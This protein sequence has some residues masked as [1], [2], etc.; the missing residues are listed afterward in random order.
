METVMWGEN[1]P[2]SLVDTNVRRSAQIAIGDCKDPEYLAAKD[3]SKGNIPNYRCYSNN[4]VVCNDINEILDNEDFWKG[5]EGNGEPYGLINLK[6]SRSCGRLGETQYPDPGVD[7]YNPCLT[8]DTMILTSEGLRPITK[9]LGKKFT[10]VVDGKL[11]DSTDTGF[12]KTGQREVYKITLENGCQIK[13]TANHKFLVENGDWIPVSDLTITHNI[14]LGKNTNFRWEGEGTFDEG[15]LVGHTTVNHCNTKLLLLSVPDDI[16]VDNY[17]PAKIIAAFV[18]GKFT[19]DP[20]VDSREGRTRYVI[21]VSNFR[22]IIDRFQLPEEGSYEFS[23]GYLKGLFDAE[24]RICGNSVSLYEL[25]GL[26]LRGIQRLLLAMGINSVIIDMDLVITGDSLA[27]FA[28]IIGFSDIDRTA[29][30]E[31]IISLHTSPTAFVS[32]IRSIRRCPSQDVYDCTIN[33]VHRFSA[34]GLISHNCAEQGLNS[35]E[36]CC[37]SELYL[38]NIKTKE[39]LFTCAKY[40]Y[41]I[42]KHSLTLPCKDSKETEQV[43]HQNMRI[44]IGVTGYLQATEVQKGWL[45]DCYK[46]LR[47]LDRQ[48]SIQHGFPFSIKLTTCK[49]SGCSRKDTLVLTNKGLLRLDEIGDVNG[50]QWQA[51]EKLQVFTDDTKTEN[52]TK[53]YVNG[54]VPTRKIITMDGAE[55]ESSLNH[56]YRLVTTD[57]KYVWKTTADLEIG[58]SLAVCLGD[59]PENIETKLDTFDLQGKM[60][61]PTLLTKDIAWFLGLFY[62]NGSVHEKGITLSFED[63]A[64]ELVV[65]LKNFFTDYFGLCLFQAESGEY[66]DNYNVDSVQFLTWLDHHSC[67]KANESQLTLPKIIR[68]ASKENATAF[69]DG[70]CRKRMD[71]KIHDD[72]GISIVSEKFARELLYVCRSVGYNARL[73]SPTSGTMNRW[74]IYCQQNLDI[75]SY[76]GLPDKGCHDRNFWLDPIVSLEASQCETYDIE[77]ENAHHYRVAGGTISHNTLSLLGGCTSGVHPGFSQYY[78]RPYPYR[79]RVSSASNCQKAWI[80]SRVCE[81]F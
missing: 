72:W 10:A 44:G 79:F 41:R 11:F 63:D 53:F 35:F 74:Y 46:Y 73:T 70:L 39:E 78:R 26:R 81:E 27:K 28:E 17:Q 16:G 4:S 54:L 31:S 37:L 23:L 47:E 61:Q 18:K 6:L 24:G 5:Y 62:A 33:E 29:Q 13:A 77:V 80:S 56:Q 20:C 67:L 21:D 9:L 71:A 15:Y 75:R 12:W 59:H 50:E 57:S 64:S 36:T 49:P 58:D 45:S 3:W 43:V 60:K 40:M 25:Y 14:V 68:M 65:W 69:I 38:P 76:K 48:Y 32:K 1:S 66:C 7:G 22:H 34:N 51:V 55:L 30:L 52:V 19:P 42:C 2:K 8:G